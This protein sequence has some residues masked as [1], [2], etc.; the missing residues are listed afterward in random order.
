MVKILHTA[1]MHLDSPFTLMD[2]SLSE[3]RRA[4]LRS[5]F[6][7][8]MMYV[9]D[10]DIDILLI[11]GDMFEHEYATKETIALAVREFEKVPQCRIVISPGNYDPYTPNCVYKK[12]QFPANVHIFTEPT[13]SEWMFTATPSP[14]LLWSEIPLRVKSP[15]TPRE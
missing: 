10:N 13:I 12:C 14:L 1:D 4:D 2:A 5:A 15:F 7:A 3:A 11:A 8:L 6:A 9:K